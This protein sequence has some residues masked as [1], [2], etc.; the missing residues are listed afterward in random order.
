MC[1]EI[2]YLHKK[3]GCLFRVGIYTYYVAKSKQ[4]FDKNC[5]KYKRTEQKLRMGN[6][7]FWVCFEGVHPDG[8]ESDEEDEDSDG[9]PYSEEDSDVD[10]KI[11]K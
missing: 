5:S 11:D 6:P 2:H 1:V 3:R 8:M 10:H 9:E 7:Y 4:G